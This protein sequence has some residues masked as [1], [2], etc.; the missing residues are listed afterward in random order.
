MIPR[1]SAARIASLASQ[2]PVVLITG[3]R[4]AGKT[5]VV[6]NL[7]PDLPYVNLERPD[8]LSLAL[9][10]PMGFLKRY[11]GQAVIF[12]EAQR[13]PE[14]MRVHPLRGAFHET[15]VVGDIIKKSLYDSPPTEWYFWSAAQG[16]EVDLIRKQGTTIQAIEI[17]AAETFKPAHKTAAKLCRH[18]RFTTRRSRTALWR[19]R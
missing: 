4:Q 1:S 10:D 17:K 14:Q 12:D 7:Y 5:T 16:P 15:M 9:D 11:A 6:R 8:I 18:C 3:P 2:F 19:S 13:W